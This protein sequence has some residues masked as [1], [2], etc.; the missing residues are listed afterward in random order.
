MNVGVRNGMKDIILTN[1]ELGESKTIMAKT[2]GK[3]DSTHISCLMWCAS[4]SD[5][6]MEPIPIK[7][8]E[9]NRKPKA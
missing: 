2:I 5:E 7:I 4:T 8:E 9:K 6:N 1:V 3:I